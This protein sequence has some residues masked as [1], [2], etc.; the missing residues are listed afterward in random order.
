MNKK[1]LGYIL[2]VSLFL[3]TGLKSFEVRSLTPYFVHEK[4]LKLKHFQKAHSRIPKEKRDFLEL[5][6]SIMTGRSAP[7]SRPMKENYKT[8]GLNHIFTPSGFHLS[9]V[10]LPFMKLLKN[11]HLQLLALIV[12]GVGLSFLPGLGALKRMVLIKGHQKI[13][14]L[15]AGFILALVIDIFFGTFQ[16]SPLSFTY[17]FL[18]L[19]IIYSGLQNL[20]L[21]IW[22]FLG[23]MILAHFQGN[24]V[25]LLLL[26]FSPILNFIYALIMPVLFIFSYPLYDW[27]LDTGLFILEK[28]QLIVNLCATLARLLPVLEIHIFTLF[29]VLLILFR[30]FN[31]L[32]LTLF[33]FSTSLNVDRARIPSLSR[34]EYSPQGKMLKTVIKENYVGVL[35]D[36]GRCRVKLVRGFW[37]ENCSPRRRSSRKKL[38]KLSYLSEEPRKSSPRG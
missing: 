29:V 35:Y 8:L 25:S 2:V 36:D 11:N 15:Q 31:F 33:V 20:S 7:L 18:F 27:Q 1:W 21:I 16:T 4:A 26:F 32:P 34:Y 37:Y 6:E 14:G 3:L 38:K 12:I 22:F 13:L 24:D 17:S 9:A 28:V 30:K 23:Q 19:G 10:L 5:W